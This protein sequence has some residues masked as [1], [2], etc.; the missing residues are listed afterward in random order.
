M[1]AIRETLKNQ[2]ENSP[3]SESFEIIR[4]DEKEVIRGIYD[5]S[6]YTDETRRST[7]VKPRIIVFKTPFYES[8]KTEIIIRNKTYKMIKHDEDANIKS[9]IWLL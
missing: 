4:G 5:E 6:V 9:V 3:F 7:S 2:I 8:G 1:N